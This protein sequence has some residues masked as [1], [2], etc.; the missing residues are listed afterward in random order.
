MI[1]PLESSAQEPPHQQAA[2]VTA[3]DAT[4]PEEK[5]RA[6]ARRRAEVFG[7]VLPETTQDER[8]GDERGPGDGDDWLR[9]NVPPHHGGD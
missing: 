6:R 9:A 4:S 7:E 8:A 5:R 3:P 2:E 1:P